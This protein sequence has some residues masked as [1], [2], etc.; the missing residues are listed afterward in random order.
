[1]G[2]RPV[3]R[4][5]NKSGLALSNGQCCFCG[6]DFLIST[7]LS[8]FFG[9]TQN[10]LFNANDSLLRD[11][12]SLSVTCIVMIGVWRYV[13]RQPANI[14][15]GKRTRLIGYFAVWV[16]PIL[17]SIIFAFAIRVAA[18]QPFDIPAG[19]M[20]PAVQRGDFLVATKWSYGY[21]HFSA[22]PFHE[23]LPQ[24][25]ILISVPKRGDVAVFKNAK[26]QNRDYIK[27][28]VGLPGDEIHMRRG[29]LHINGQPVKKDFVALEDTVCDG[30][31]SQAPT[32]RGTLETG[33]SYIVQECHGDNGRLDNVGPYWVPEGHLFVL[34]DN[35]DQSQDSRV[36]RM[37]GYVPQENLIGKVRLNNRVRN[38]PT[39]S[40]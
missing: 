3:L 38:A 11:I 33:V 21:N 15:K 25:H 18:F 7:R 5:K 2:G 37:M 40:E 39:K 8:L 24:G 14:E 10:A 12:V 34:G 36:I 4:R 28:I 30:R 26:D 23:L 29:H 22:T 27:R 6:D 32:Y 1:M 17:A 20:H 31:S 19:S 13:S 35:R 9:P 16:L